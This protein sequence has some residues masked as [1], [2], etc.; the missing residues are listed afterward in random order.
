MLSERYHIPVAVSISDDVPLDEDVL[1]GKV[2][3]TT[4]HQFKGSERD[5]VIVYGADASYFRFLGRD[6][7]DDR[8]PNATFVALTRARKQLVVLH[9]NKSSVMPFVDWKTLEN[10][11]QFIN[12]A[13]SE[14]R[15]QYPPGRPLQLGLLLPQSVKA[16]E[17]SRHVQHEV[18][19]ELV[20]QYINIKELAV[21]LPRSSCIDVAEKV[22]TNE[23]KMHYEAVS[24][25]N[26][27]AVTA[28]FEWKTWK[29]CMTYDY[30]KGSRV[31]PNVPDNPATQPRWFAE[32]AAKYEARVS[33]YR[34]RYIQMSGHAFDWLDESLEAAT[35]RL[36]EQFQDTSRIRF[37]VRLETNFAVEEGSN[38][39]EPVQRTKLVGRADIIVDEPSMHE[40]GVPTIWEIK[41][42]SSLSVEH[43]VQAVI[44]GYLW[45]AQRGLNMKRKPVFPKLIV[46]NVRD[47]A[48]WE[49]STTVD[50][51]RALIEG[52]L[53]AKYTAKGESP[54]QEFLEKCRK[55]REEVGD[56]MVK[57]NEWGDYRMKR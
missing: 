49:I 50:N 33:N 5:L 24:D 43:A 46:F 14:P 16:T 44:Y 37:E 48:K 36:G 1:N 22:L 31:P 17:V 18:L 20:K 10:T 12:L 3:V 25:L 38:K 7:P 9:S 53:R 47:G 15:P 21:P 42:V 26:G 4:Y 6:L 57:N 45:C 52:L 19:D 13:N 39:W 35:E 41:F 34:S 11:F 28:A 2:A 40:E 23:A 55:V 56:V 27:L 32:E 54:T 8:C 51:A 30:R 29:T